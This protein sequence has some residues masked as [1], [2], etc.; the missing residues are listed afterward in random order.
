MLLCFGTTLSAQDTDRDAPLVLPISFDIPV[1]E[2]ITQEAI[3]DWWTLQLVEGD[4]IRIEMAASEGLEPLIGVLDSEREL[5]ARSD[6]EGESV[7]NDIVSIDFTAQTDGE[8]TI[9]ATRAGNADGTST[10]DY[11]LLVSLQSRIPQRENDRIPVEFR[12]DDALVTTALYLSPNDEFPPTLEGLPF[13]EQARLRVTVIGLDDFE[14]IIHIEAGADGIE[15]CSDLA[16]ATHEG[17]AYDVPGIDPGTVDDGA[18]IAEAVLVSEEMAWAAENLQFTIGSRDGQP[19][20]YIVLIE[21][22]AL[23]DREDVDW[24]DIRRGP[25]A[26]NTPTSLYMIATSLRFDPYLTLFD[27]VD[28]IYATCDDAGVGDCADMPAITDKSVTLALGEEQTDI[29][30][31]RFDAGVMLEPDR[32]ELQQLRIESRSNSTSGSYAILI[33]GKLPAP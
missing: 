4:Q 10:G 19:G 7:A 26:R 1:S 24:I 13:N 9:I 23:Q 12:C 20:R 18:H 8:H 22:M 15:A 16:P 29:S 25:L 33:I 31:N 28:F 11:T 30:G 3:F 17:Y 5:L 27:D 32:L 2:S 14:P 21:G 6:A